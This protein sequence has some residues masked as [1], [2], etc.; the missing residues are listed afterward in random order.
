M[1]RAIEDLTDK[2]GH[3]THVLFTDAANSY[4]PEFLQHVLGPRV[5][6]A[7]TRFTLNGGKVGV[8]WG[9]GG[10]DKGGVLFSTR[11]VLAAKGFLASLPPDPS[12]QAI[13]EANWWFCDRAIKAPD[14]VSTHIA[15][16]LLFYRHPATRD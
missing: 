5:D 10:V 11:A 14:K 13:H 2:C 8:H 12:P 9:L 6:L 4:H 7:T 16:A 3:C 15:Q 1:D